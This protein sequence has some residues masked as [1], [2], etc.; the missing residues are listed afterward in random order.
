MPQ[1]RVNVSSF[2]WRAG[3]A[4]AR[5]FSE[6]ILFDPPEPQNSG[7][8]TR[9]RDF[10]TFL[11]TF[12]FSV[13]A[14][15]ISDLLRLELRPSC[16]VFSSVDIVGSLASKLPSIIQLCVFVLYQTAWNVIEQHKTD[17]R[18]LGLGYRFPASTFEIVPNIHDVQ[19]HF[20][21]T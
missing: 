5:C 11:R 7:K 9:F 4:P 12:L 18:D 21:N 3:S 8:N 15:S 10:P 17:R 20:D 13:L 16:G 2:I 6:P 1:R 14:F 19:W